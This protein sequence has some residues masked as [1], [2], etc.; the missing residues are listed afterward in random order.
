MAA[1]HG[2]NTKILLNGYNISSYLQDA[3]VAGTRDEADI[4]GFE[5]TAK[6]F[7]TGHK[8][9]AVSMSGTFDGAANAID[10]QFSAI[11]AGGTAVPFSY[12]PDSDTVGKRAIFGKFKQ[13]AYSIVSSITDAVRISADGRTDSDLDYGV[14]LHAQG[15]KTATGDGA[16]HDWG[17]ASA[18]ST[19]FAAQAQVTAI[20]GDGATFT[21]KL[22]D[23]A[24]GVT[25]ADVTG[26]AFTAI[27]AVGAQQLTHASTSV[28]RYTR[29]SWTIA[30][31]GPSVTFQAVLAKR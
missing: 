1:S 26:G 30:G 7:I 21:P 10:Q 2:K 8:D 6:S 19:G 29:I 14:S 22:Q 20:S 16:T 4:T 5:A 15:A 25:W 24:D 3:E 23:S 9:G 31:T 17:A 12:A 13:L 27:T 18:T 11:L 28:R